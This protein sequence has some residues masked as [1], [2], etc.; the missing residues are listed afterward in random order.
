MT[1]WKRM[2]AVVAVVIALASCAGLP[3]RDGTESRSVQIDAAHTGVS[4]TKVAAR[5]RLLW[6][7]HFGDER[8]LTVPIIVGE[9]VVVG[10]KPATSEPPAPPSSMVVAYDRRT[11]AQRWVH[12]LS[13]NGDITLAYADQHVIVSGPLNDLSA[14]DL[15][16]GDLLWS[17][18]VD[19][20]FLPPPTVFGRQVFLTEDSTD[21]HD[22]LRSFDLDTGKQRWSTVVEDESDAVPAAT[23]DG[24]FL[25]AAE[26]V[27][28]KLALSDG[29]VLWRRLFGGTG[30]GGGHAVPRNGRVYAADSSGDY[31]PPVA[32]VS[33]ILDQATG[34][35]LRD[36]RTSFQPVVGTKNLIVG[37]STWLHDLTADG[38]SVRWAYHPRAGEHILTQP[39]I[40]GQTLF[41]LVRG[42]AGPNQPPT[43]NPDVV[44]VGIRMADGTESSRLTVGGNGD[45]APP[46]HTDNRPVMAAANGV[47]AFSWNVLGPVDDLYVVG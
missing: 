16:T 41:V 29:H 35:T 19:G 25:T 6:S 42:L 21:G 26:N 28:T 32:G 11:G 46:N 17:T 18:P 14:L 12:Q 27:T 3:A 20:V 13:A 47:L 4:T 31:E 10:M 43:S 45:Q 34:A 33:K 39:V 5:P 22:R 24:V 2:V 30:G 40:A 38:A 23:A 9:L 36:F 8:V 37:T 7:K 44:L 15:H 1:R